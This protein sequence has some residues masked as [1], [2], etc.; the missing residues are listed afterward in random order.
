MKNDSGNLSKII[1]KIII[2][3]YEIKA[4]NYQ[5]DTASIKNIF[6]CFLRKQGISPAE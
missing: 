3:K 1:I 2:I 4:E 6:V 5:K